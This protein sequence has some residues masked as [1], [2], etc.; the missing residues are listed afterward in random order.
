MQYSNPFAL[1]RDLLKDEELA[2]YPRKLVLEDCFEYGAM[3][4]EV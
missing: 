1:L 3:D 4:R 2:L